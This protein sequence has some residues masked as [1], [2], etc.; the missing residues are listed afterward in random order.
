MTIYPVILCGGTGS[1]LWP[2]SRE[3]FPKQF[4]PLAG[5]CTMLQE[6][7]G[8]VTGEG[9]APP[10]LLANEDHRFIVA[11]Q[12][13]VAALPLRAIV[14]EP[15]GRGT[16]PAVCVA[17]LDVLADDAEAM[18]L[19]MPSDHVVTDSQA[20]AA[21]VDTAAR[22]AADGS[23]VTFGI[24][25]EGPET[26]Y[27]YIRAGAP[28]PH[29]E[30]C[31]AVDKFVE[32]PDRATAETYLAE[33]G[34]SWNSGLF[35]FKAA[36]YVAELER[37]R[38]DMVSAA[39]AALA[40]A[41]A[42]NDFLRLDAEAFAACPAG[43]VDTAVMEHTARAVVVPVSMGWSDV[44]AWSALWTLGD[45]DPDGNVA[46]GDVMLHDARNC[47]VRSDDGMLAAVVGAEDIVVVVSADAV[48]VSA[49]DRV[50]DVKAVVERLK[51]DGRSE[52][53]SHPTEHRPWGSFRCIDRGGRFQVKH[54]TVA[55]GAS[56]S[57]QLHYHR[58]EHWVVVEGTARV[59]RG[60]ETFLLAENES[61]Y[62]PPGTVHRL[63]NP[64]RL[65]LSLIE[66]QSGAYL[67]E[68]DIV[69][70][71]DSFGRS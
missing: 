19:V 71:V 16:A 38:P 33:G 53:R 62:I 42:D 27:G 56:I 12:M 28:H 64:G 9:F 58:A 49:R 41:Q 15:V 22:A 6:T 46:R 13:R 57:L 65:P 59:T 61:T 1:R 18:L 3:R 24:A 70:L 60:E 23:L 26:G 10:L 54:I 5:D 7:A 44:G 55:P 11:E 29:V 68:D 35:L 25:P 69:R 20:F 63:E 34:Y 21:A 8:R 30:G 50:Q 43:S 67:G 47:Y 66:V 31:A 4:L 17:A 14:L 45:K 40:G 51:R 2:L 52:H 32:K 37:L 48:L 36:A 39:R